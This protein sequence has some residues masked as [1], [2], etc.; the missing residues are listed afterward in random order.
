[1]TKKPASLTGDL[2]ARKGEAAPFSTEPD[3][4]MTLAT[5]RQPQFAGLGQPE[6]A[7]E[8]ATGP[9]DNEAPSRLYG[10]DTMETPRMVTE[11]ERPLP[12]EPEIIYTP[13][14]L[15]GG[16]S[17]TR[18]IAGGLIGLVLIG[19]VILALSQ[20]KTGGVAPVAP[21]IADAPM[22]SAQPAES[23]P[24]EP[25]APSDEINIPSPGGTMSG[26]ADVDTVAAA[27]EPSATEEPA[28]AE[29]APMPEMDPP[30]PMAEVTAAPEAVAQTPA[31]PI[32]EA[33]VS[34]A[35]VSE[36]PVA[37]A[38]VAEP[39]AEAPVADAPAKAAPAS[40]GAYVVQLL[41]LRDEA[42]AKA[43]WSK[44]TVKYGSL[45]D[46]ALDIEKAD[47]G[48]KGTFYRVRAAGFTSKSSAT[49]FCANLKKAGQDCMVRKR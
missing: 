29:T 28:P 44:L 49:S 19:G 8:E 46:H 4:R 24:V 47:L 20:P 15:D 34:E 42:S 43:A 25:P 36:A 21:E 41:A 2:L 9:L 35:P 40:G 18:L 30:A 10:D 27:L 39:A 7:P 6:L 37:E 31:A 11:P 38:P 14:E 1:M 32:A 17:R 13:E 12:P 33:P 45:A 23:E 5:G 22:A 16:S 3:A 26:V 48:D